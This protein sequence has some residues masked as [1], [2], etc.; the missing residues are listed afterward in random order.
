MA[1][2]EREPLQL[3]ESPPPDLLRNSDKRVHRRA[4]DD[5]KM[6]TRVT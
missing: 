6:L 3:H 4:A 2:F 5:T 1:V